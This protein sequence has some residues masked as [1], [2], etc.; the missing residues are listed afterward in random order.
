MRPSLLLLLAAVATVSA[1]DGCYGGTACGAGHGCCDCSMTQAECTAAG[2][3]WMASCISTS[4]GDSMCATGTEPTISGCYNH[5]QGCD[6]SKTEQTCSGSWYAGCAA[7]VSGGVLTGG[8]MCDQRPGATSPPAPPPKPPQAPPS[9]PQRCIVQ[10]PPSM[11]T[12]PFPFALLSDHLPSPSRRGQI[13]PSRLRRR[14]PST[15]RATATSRAANTCRNRASAS[16]TVTAPI[17][18][19]N[20]QRATCAASRWARATISCRTPPGTTRAVAKG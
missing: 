14:T 4:S 11:P 19:P 2:K 1:W 16:A 9:P 5:G 3:T 7:T 13:L 12:G 10:V 17:M 20:P 8:N 18:G 15:S 6:C